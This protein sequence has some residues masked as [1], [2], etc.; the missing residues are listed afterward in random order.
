MNHDR[1]ARFAHD[2]WQADGCP[3]GKDAEHWLIAE[4]YCR[5]Q[6]SNTPTY[7]I[8]P[9]ARSWRQ[10][11]GQQPPTPAV[12]VNVRTPTLLEWLFNW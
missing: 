5:L 7:G 9:F 8:I 3:T 11:R 10:G 1:I 6:D 2:I 12:T 4:D